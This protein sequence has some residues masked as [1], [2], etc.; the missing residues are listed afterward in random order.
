LAVG[1]LLITAACGSDDI[2][3]LDSPDD[4]ISGS[5]VASGGGVS[6]APAA[7]EPPPTP[8]G[9]DRATELVGRWE[10]TDYVLPDG[11]GLTNVVG[12]GPVFLE[13]GADGTLS[14]STGCNEGT[15]NYATSGAY[16][17]PKSALDDT[18]EGQPITIGPSFLQTEIGC[19]G[20][21]GD[22][23]RDLPIDMGAAT[24][25]RIDDDR[26]LLL[27]EFL[28]IQASKAG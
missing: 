16:V 15:A 3:G 17:V 25:F 6:D 14:Y 1:L 13:F 12:D 18:L 10:V 19:D 24:R 4:Q 2:S 28:L 7:N 21:L 27:N 23:D 20:F 9:D 11:S 8:A 5:T 22:Q 26:L